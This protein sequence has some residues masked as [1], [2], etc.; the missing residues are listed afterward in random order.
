MRRVPRVHAAELK[1][2]PC[3]LVALAAAKAA[4]A[5]LHL[6]HRKGGQ[7]PGVIAESLCPDFLACI[8]KPQRSI[9]VSGTNGK[10]MTTNLI[11][12]LLVDNGFSPIVNRAGSNIASG[13]ESAL[14]ED[15]RLNG[16][17]RRDLASIELDEL[18]C[19]TVLPYITPD[20]MLV[21][22]LYQ[23]NFLRDATPEFIFSVMSAYIP[24][25][26]HLVLNADDLISCWLAPRVKRRTYFSLGAA[27][28]RLASAEGNVA[29]ELPCC[30]VC[31]GRMVYSGHTLLH[32]GTAC[33]SS[34]G[35][36]NPPADYE[37]VRLDESDNTM[38]IRE[39]CHEGA[40][41][42]AYRVSAYGVPNLYNQLAAIATL[43]EFG[44]PAQDLARSFKGGVGISAI[45]YTEEHVE[46]K[47][48][49]TCS[50]KTYNGSGTTA[51]L[52]ALQVRSGRKAL[53]L[54]LNDYL[55]N[56]PGKA[57]FCGWYYLIDGKV[58]ADESIEQI[59]VFGYPEQETN[60][61]AMELRLRMAGVPQ[62]KIDVA[63]SEQAAADAID[64][65]EVDGVYALF[66]C[67]NGEI[68]RA[69]IACV[70]ER[71]IGRV[72]TTGKER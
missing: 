14:I 7:L 37:V 62:E 18:S 21:T 2:T 44:I 45:R 58:L 69:C 36:A 42:H 71:L 60:S 48:L 10:T 40:P 52:R 27:G 54:V 64:L 46:G 53:I 68:A 65:N 55:S 26:T 29:D 57:E 1:R 23:D 11:D 43:R 5:G 33:C 66:D 67:Y 17:L 63:L 16:T 70:K 59:V 51:S 6:A 72:A 31:G 35:L 9:F 39:N 13:V 41:E 30:P 22:N 3:F 47:D 61:H 4:Q 20:L 50:A 15:A 34:C 32:L 28:A 12:D 49:V 38:V 19:K 8:D 24:A 25:G 56:N